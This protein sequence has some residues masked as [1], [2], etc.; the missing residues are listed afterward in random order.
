MEKDFQ[1]I[2]KRIEF[3]D[4]DA[5]DQTH[6]KGDAEKLRTTLLEK[7]EL[8]RQTLEER[9]RDVQSVKA[10]LGMKQIFIIFY[11]CLLVFLFSF[12][13]SFLYENSYFSILPSSN[14]NCL[15]SK[16]K[17]QQLA[18]D[19]ATRK[20]EVTIKQKDAECVVRHARDSLILSTKDYENV[21][22][23]LKK[24]RIVLNL[25][26]QNLPGL[27]G[28]L[29]DQEVSLRHLKDDILH[30]QK[31]VVKMKE[32]I[33]YHVARLLQQEGL[34]GDRKKDLEDIIGE[35]DGLEGKV[36]EWLAEGKRQSKLLSVLSAQR[37]I[38]ARETSRIE[39]KEKD[40]KQQVHM[41]ELVILDLT[42]RCN[43]IANRLKEFSALYEVVKN[44]RNKYVNLIQSSSQAL[45]EMR[46]KIRI[47]N[48]EVEILGN[49]RTA[50]DLALQKEHNAH[51][52]AQNQRDALR[53]DLNRLL[54]EYRTRQST[55]EQQIQEI[56]KLNV[57]I[58]NLEK[59][60]LVLKSRFEK[61]VEQRNITGVQ[62][63]DRNDELCILYERSNQQQEAL[64][65]GELETI[66]KEE[67]L[68]V[69]RL[70]AEEL[71]RQYISAQ[72]RLPELQILRDRGSVLE[73]ELK[74]EYKK[75]EELSTKLEDP[76]NLA[77]WRPLD[78]EDPDMDQLLA[79]IKIL[80]D[81]LDHK[82]EQVLEKELVLEEITSLT[83][84]L[85]TQ[86]IN[87]RE[88]AKILADE[89]NDLHSRIRDVTKK[90]LASVA[91]LS[92]Y[93][94]RFYKFANISIS[95]IWISITLCC[96]SLGH[97]TASATRALAKREGSGGSG[98]AIHPQRGSQQ[99]SRNFVGTYG[100]YP[101]TAR[102]IRCQARGGATLA[103]SSS[104]HLFAHCSRAETNCLYP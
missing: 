83:E 46:E 52:Q 90:M 14:F 53:Q 34:E 29:K 65:K 33:D 6:K 70:H 11:F 5:A 82:R 99:R 62:L 35:V 28:Q 101:A 61:A 78:G 79:K 19:I 66:K 67:E 18:H 38:K 37:D 26:K 4:K 27:E 23:A 8:N 80:E 73:A 16:D 55:V 40:A 86:A 76:R 93:Q 39:S 7:L 103:L 58:N 95:F 20:M 31:E 104:R 15:V 87:K 59:E 43:E 24:R 102:G 30:K 3:L 88:G 60:M 77:R 41:K 54:S 89:L 1:N 69:L 45:A 12:E 68:R 48:N 36:V 10:K 50:K 94:V 84:K 57:V 91:E 63:I 9:E 56:D 85:R 2:I 42:K 49:E 51:Q 74:S 71:K 13:R 96:T 75:T 22:R 17:A 92:M 97:S 100:S 21:K 72:K 47:L 44:E 98:V 64:R 32:E 25:C 81:Q